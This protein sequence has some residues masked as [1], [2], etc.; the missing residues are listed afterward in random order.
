[1]R[2][3]IFICLAITMLSC[4]GEIVTIKKQIPKENLTLIGEDIK[5][6]IQYTNIACTLNIIEGG[7]QKNYIEL[8]L[9]NVKFENITQAREIAKKSY[10]IIKKHYKEYG[11]YSLVKIRLKQAENASQKTYNFTYNTF[12]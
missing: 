12:D 5:E 9:N 4:T 1:M 3:L 10:T 2:L 8:V 6:Y 11:K 7:K